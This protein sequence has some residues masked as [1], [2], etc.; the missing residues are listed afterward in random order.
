MKVVSAL[1]LPLKWERRRTPF[2]DIHCMNLFFEEK[3]GEGGKRA[4]LPSIYL[5]KVKIN[6]F[7][8]FSFWES[9]R[10]RECV[11]VSGNHFFLLLLHMEWRRRRRRSVAWVSHTYKKIHEKANPN[12]NFSAG[13]TK[14]CILNWEKIRQNDCLTY[15]L[16]R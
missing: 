9:K 13:D 5:Y 1:C 14:K 6:G 10:R 3:R 11:Y 12:L 2:G 4:D 15:N 7:P 16:I 8:V